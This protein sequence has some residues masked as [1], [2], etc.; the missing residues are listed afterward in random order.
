[1]KANFYAII[2]ASL[3]ISSVGW[4]EDAKSIVK[5]PNPQDVLTQYLAEEANK[6]LLKVNQDQAIGLAC[7]ELCLGEPVCSGSCAGSGLV[8]KEVKTCFTTPKKCF[9]ENNEVRKAAK[10]VLSDIQ[11]G[12]G[13]NN[14]IVGKN[15]W[16]RQRLGF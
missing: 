9:G 6:E 16:L 8:F 3:F 14:D 10:N 13:P 11:N 7:V 12:T 5:V 1:M 4:A 2:F 15:G